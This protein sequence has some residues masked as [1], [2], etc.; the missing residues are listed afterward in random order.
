MKQL[1]RTSTNNVLPRICENPKCGKPRKPLGWCD[2]CGL[3][4][5]EEC[6]FH[7]A[8]DK[9]LRHADGLCLEASKTLHAPP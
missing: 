2:K 3:T 9:V 5:C 7:S 8:L 6:G 4:V 1:P